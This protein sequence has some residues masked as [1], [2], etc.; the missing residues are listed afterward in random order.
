[1]QMLKNNQEELTQLINNGAEIAQSISSKKLS[2]IK[3]KIG[4]IN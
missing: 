3:N 4:F 2:E 1:M